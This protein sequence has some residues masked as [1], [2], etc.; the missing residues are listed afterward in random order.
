M[1]F[2]TDILSS[3][4]DFPEKF[5][6]FIVLRHCSW[7][8][9]SSEEFLNILKKVKKLGKTLCFA[10]W[11]TRVT[12]NEQIPHLLAVL[13]QA[14]YEC[15]KKDS[16]SNVRTLFTP[17]DIQNLVEFAGWQIVSEKVIDSSFLQDE[18]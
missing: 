8:L 18:R 4:V 17:K 6:D 9:N 2:E 13:I 14:Q 3:E 15:F 12:T 10:E 11:D 16:N 1:E 7:Y 5:F